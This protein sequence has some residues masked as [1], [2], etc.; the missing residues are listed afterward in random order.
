MLIVNSSV[1]ALTEHVTGPGLMR[2]G[3]A[4]LRQNAV[5]VERAAVKT[6][7]MLPPA[8]GR[9]GVSCSDGR[10]AHPWRGKRTGRLLR[11]G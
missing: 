3:Y 8:G 6:V 5:E 10:T 4:L 11:F 9:L 2:G 1:S 7:T